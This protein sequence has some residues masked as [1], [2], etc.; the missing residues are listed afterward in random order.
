MRLGLKAAGVLATVGL[1]MGAAQELEIAT[2]VSMLEGPTVDR[3]GNAYFTDVLTERIMKFSTSGALSV[4][5]KQSISWT[6]SRL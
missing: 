2:F 3:D 6:A 1:A 4:Y 5:R